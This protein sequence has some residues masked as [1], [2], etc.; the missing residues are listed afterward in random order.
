MPSF[1]TQCSNQGTRR[2]TPRS[3]DSS[4]CNF[5]EFCSTHFL[6]ALI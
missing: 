5:S 1:R 3:L 4:K 6:Q 2:H